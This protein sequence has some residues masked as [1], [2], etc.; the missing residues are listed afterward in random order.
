MVVEDETVVHSVDNDGIICVNLNDFNELSDSIRFRT[1]IDCLTK[2][3]NCPKDISNFSISML[4]R[5]GERYYLSNLYL[6]AIP[7]RTEGLYR[8]DVDHDRALYHGKEFFIQRDVKYDSM[9]I[10]IIQILES[11]YNLSTTFAMIRQCHECDFI[12][13]AYN[14]EKILD[15]QKLY[16]QV[17]DGFEQFI[18]HFID[19][20][21]QEII[22]ALPEQKWLNILTDREY[23]RKVITRKELFHSL[24]MLSSRELQCLSLIADGLNTK[25]VAEQLFLS[26]ET[27]ST[28][29]KSIRQKMDCKNIAEAVAKAFRW[30]LL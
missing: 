14:K 2:Q 16:Y 7:Y 9:Q 28:H 24:A 25:E 10:P 15:P 20:M 29:A 11:R 30:G 6:W 4:F 17:R 26:N 12:I 13:E 18:C 3:F 19:A 8:G 27:V 5:G 21:Q 23:R 1:K 22:S